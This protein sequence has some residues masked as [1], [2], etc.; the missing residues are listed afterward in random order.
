MKYSLFA[1]IILSMLFMVPMAANATDYEDYVVDV[2]INDES[3]PLQVLDWNAWY[4]AKDKITFGDA[5]FLGDAAPVRVAGFQYD[6]KV[7]NTGKIDLVAYQVNVVVF[8]AFNEYLDTFGIFHGAILS[9]DKD[10]KRS[11]MAMFNG[12]DMFLT[13]FIWVDKARDSD[14]NIYFADLTKV[15][16]TIE[17][18]MGMEI[19]EEYLKPGIIL[20]M[21]ESLRMRWPK[22]HEVGVVN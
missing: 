19:P 1:L 14:G 8:S 20:E 6:L 15:K 21:N 9:P 17:E 13:F 16:S 18:K 22:Y 11:N 2:L 12:D 4:R 7:K 3:C 5:L 10:M